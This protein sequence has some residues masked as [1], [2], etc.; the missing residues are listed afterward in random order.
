MTYRDE[1]G[2]MSSTI[3]REE[4][5]WKNLAGLAVSWNAMTCSA[6]FNS[7]FKAMKQNKITLILLKLKQ[8]KVLV[9]IENQMVLSR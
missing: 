1:N 6:K 8:A 2:N 4:N 3:V 7:C 9:K 5:K